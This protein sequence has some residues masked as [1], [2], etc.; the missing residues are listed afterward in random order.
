MVLAREQVTEQL[1]RFGFGTL[2]QFIRPPSLANQASGTVT[3]AFGE[4]DPREREAA[5]GAFWLIAYEATNGGGVA[6]VLPQTHLCPPAHESHTRPARIIGDERRVSAEGRVSLRMTQDEPFN[7][8]PR[9]RVADRFLDGGRLA[10]LG[11]ARKIDS[12]PYR[13]EIARERRSFRTCLH[14]WRRSVAGRRRF[15]F[16]RRGMLRMSGFPDRSVAGMPDACR[17]MRLLG[18][19]RLVTGPRHS[20]GRKYC[21]HSQGEEAR[22]SA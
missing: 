12:I 13:R 14:T 10:R 4:Q 15:G 18:R 1:E 21:E 6:A 22:P 9:S 19:L 11:L 8:F 16:R 2:R 17:L 20:V 7:E 3:V 5:L